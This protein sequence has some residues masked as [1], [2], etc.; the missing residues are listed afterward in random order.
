M[1]NVRL[2]TVQILYAARVLFVTAMNEIKQ[3]ISDKVARNATR[4]FKH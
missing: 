2:K 4:Q 1:C 3:S